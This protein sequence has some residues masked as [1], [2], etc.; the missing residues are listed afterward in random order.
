MQRLMGKIHYTELVSIIA[1]PRKGL[2]GGELR[3]LTL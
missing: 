1:S 2:V 3:N